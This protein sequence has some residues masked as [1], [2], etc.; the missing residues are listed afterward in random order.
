M[1]ITTVIEILDF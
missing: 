1:H